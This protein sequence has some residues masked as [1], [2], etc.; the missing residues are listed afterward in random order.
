MPLA[1][2]IMPSQ[3]V[4]RQRLHYDPETGVLTFNHQSRECFA[5]DGQFKQ[6]NT[7]YGGKVAGRRVGKYW[8][9][10]LYKHEC[11]AHRIIWKWMTGEEPSVIIDHI[12]RN[13]LNNRWSNLRAATYSQSQGNTRGGN[14][15]TG[16]KGAFF[17]PR[18]RSKPFYAKLQNINLGTFATAQEAHE[19]YCI[20]AQAKFGEF[21]TSK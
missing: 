15:I 18:K 17:D 10:S 9:I 12:D 4:L 13:E 21:W 1:S 11:Y 14:N 19:A 2:R 8:A 6:W 20:A 5:S 16:L 3:D 7:R